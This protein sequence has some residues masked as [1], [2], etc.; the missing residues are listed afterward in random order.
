[1]KQYTLNAV[2][3]LIQA[4]IDKEG[5][6]HQLEEGVLGH[7]V[8]MLTACGCKT[9]II[10]EVFL[11]SWSSAHTVRFYNEMPKKYAK[12]MEDL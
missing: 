5:E 8:L 6:M 10:K 7:G 12:M 11:N 9:A 3:Q 2:D 4:Y 1:M